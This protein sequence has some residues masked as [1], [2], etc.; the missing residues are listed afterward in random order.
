MRPQTVLMSAG[1]VV[2]VG[3]PLAAGTPRLLLVVFAV[4]L[5]LALA[6]V[7]AA[8]VRMLRRGLRLHRTRRA[9]ARAGHPPRFRPMGASRAA[10]LSL[11]L[12]LP[13]MV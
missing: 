12:S 2:M 10:E 11:V 6:G 4:G 8:G 9:A 1:W 7:V 5:V 13:T 3:S